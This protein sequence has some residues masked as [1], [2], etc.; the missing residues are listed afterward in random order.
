MPSFLHA[1]L[2]MMLDHM[3]KCKSDKRG[4]APVLEYMF[5]FTIF[6]LILSI[7][8]SSIDTLFLPIDTDSTELQEKG[9]V[10]AENLMG[11][12]GEIRDPDDPLLTLQNWESIPGSELNDPDHFEVL[13]LGLR[14]N[15]GN[16]GVLSYNKMIK[17]T[18]E[19][20]ETVIRDALGIKNNI[21]FNISVESIGSDII[22]VSVGRSATQTTK[23]LISI[24]RFC[25]ID[26]ENAKIMGKLSVK[27]FYGGKNTR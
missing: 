18:G 13:S 7:Y 14:S 3:N 9:I 8:F 16:Y 20:E 23:N 27:L 21:A 5:S 26:N 17:M 12:P 22:R 11:A 1:A 15:K 24:E 25:V 10:I 19:L 2:L 6:I 4:I